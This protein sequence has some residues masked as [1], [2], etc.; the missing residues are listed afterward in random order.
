M[1]FNFLCSFLVVYIG[2]WTKTAVVKWN[3]YFILWWCVMANP[4]L[5]IYISFII[6]FSF[7][8]QILLHK[9]TTIV[10]A[11]SFY[12]ALKRS[13]FSVIFYAY[14]KVFLRWC[15]GVH[16]LVKWVRRQLVEKEWWLEK[17]WYGWKNVTFLFA[18]VG[19]EGLDKRKPLLKKVP[20]SSFSMKNAVSCYDGFIIT[21]LKNYFQS[22]G[23]NLLM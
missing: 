7:P 15:V 3:V 12:T 10:I 6:L 1:V 14:T 11:R 5:R 17:I 13:A 18:F 4:F 19:E 16:F 20:I 2:L 8:H 23:I 22:N 9:L 21:Y